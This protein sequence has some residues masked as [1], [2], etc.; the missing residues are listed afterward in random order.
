[1]NRVVLLIAATVVFA[2]PA[3]ASAGGREGR[4]ASQGLGLADRARGAS[5]PLGLAR[6]RAISRLS[7]S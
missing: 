3:V 4:A 2:L 5:C 7:L 6:S 1:M